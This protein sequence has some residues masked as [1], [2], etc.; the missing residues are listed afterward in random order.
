MTSTL[1]RPERDERLFLLRFVQPGLVGLIDGT[2]STL[3]PIF[4]AAFISGPRAALLVGL[5]TSL[6][7][8]ISMGLS[9]ALSDDGARTDR[10]SAIWRGVITGIMTAL[11]GT[12][13]SLPFLIDSLRPAIA[14]AVLVAATELVAI[15]L[16]R[17]RYLD[18]SM[19]SSLVQVILGGALIIGVG[20]LIGNAA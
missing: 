8:G 9:E 2:L 5:A 14:L 15:A 1:I 12:L 16:I 11:G 10:G 19:R 7:A 4:S 17:K 18:M 3:A 20:F 13:H 6:G